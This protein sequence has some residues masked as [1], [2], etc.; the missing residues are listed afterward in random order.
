M[1]LSS[2]I[3]TPLKASKSPFI[4]LSKSG[5]VA[6]YCPKL[7]N[8]FFLGQDLGIGWYIFIDILIKPSNGIM[9]Y[10]ICS[11]ISVFQLVY[12]L[13]TY[14]EEYPFFL[15]VLIDAWCNI[16]LS[17]YKINLIISPFSYFYF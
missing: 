1:F 5:E 2:T 10:G 14:I 3:K 11:L 4:E 8:C 12:F 15:A 6:L 17:Q 13:S 16:N 7:T 9:S